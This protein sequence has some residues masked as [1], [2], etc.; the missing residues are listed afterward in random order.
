MS[1]E[2]LEDT[3]T[4]SFVYST[5]AIASMRDEVKKTNSSASPLAL[6]TVLEV[7]TRKES[8]YYQLI[9]LLHAGKTTE[10][11]HEGTESA[12]NYAMCSLLQSLINGTPA[13]TLN[14][15]NKIPRS[16]CMS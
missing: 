8:W 12:F 13:H 3:Q 7:K 5:V 11:S 9:T 1:K 16:A 2:K 6:H 10:Y 14:G 15:N 4:S